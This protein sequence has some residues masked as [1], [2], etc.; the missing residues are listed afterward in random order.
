MLDE[1]VNDMIDDVLRLMDESPAEKDEAEEAQKAEAE[2]AEEAHKAAAEEAQKPADRDTIRKKSKARPKRKKLWTSSMKLEL[3]ERERCGAID[4]LLLR[5]AGR[6]VSEQDEGEQML[7]EML[8]ASRDEE[9]K[10]RRFAIRFQQ[11]KMTEEEDIAALHSAGLHYPEIWDFASKT[12]RP[13][14]EQDDEDDQDVAFEKEY[15]YSKST[16]SGQR[17]LGMTHEQRQ[18]KDSEIQMM[19]YRQHE[20]R[21]REFRHWAP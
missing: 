11:S 14:N 6:D 18:E 20:K 19:F 13:R 17:G 8:K 16:D 21:Y 1:E 9:V 2:E 7:Q 3:V 10:Q 15:W 5:D 4:G 12:Y